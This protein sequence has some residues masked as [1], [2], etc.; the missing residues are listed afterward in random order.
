[1]PLMV[2]RE[3]YSSLALCT[4]TSEAAASYTHF[5]HFVP[6]NTHNWDKNSL[7]DTLTTFHCDCLFAEIEDLHHEFI[8]LSAIILVDDTYAVGDE[9][10]FA[11]RCATPHAKY[12]HI[13]IWNAH[14]YVA[15]NEFYRTRFDLCLFSTEQVKAYRPYCGISG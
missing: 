12:E 1:M 13:A 8:P 11:P 9:E 4:C 6:L 14:D 5:A 15:G 10:A 3:F 2:L 7:R